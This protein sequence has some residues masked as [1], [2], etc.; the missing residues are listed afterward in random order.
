MSMAIAC[1]G[2]VKSGGFLSSFSLSTTQHSSDHIETMFRFRSQHLKNFKQP[3]I[4][5]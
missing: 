1:Y 5:Q 4:K 3:V 2:T